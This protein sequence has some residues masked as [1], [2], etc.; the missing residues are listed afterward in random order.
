MTL[1]N[2]L[3]CFGRSVALCSDNDTGTVM[4]YR[5]KKRI[6]KKVETCPPLIFLLN[7][8]AG[9]SSWFICFRIQSALAR[10]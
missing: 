2:L 5:R 4:E 7:Q 6:E 10:R 3:A 9:G 1:P 8:N